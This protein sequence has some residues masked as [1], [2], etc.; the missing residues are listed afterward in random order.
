MADRGVFGGGGVNTCSQVMVNIGKIVDVTYI[1][2]KMVTEEQ[3]ILPFYFKDA[4]GLR[5]C[6]LNV[7]FLL[8]GWKVG[9]VG[10]TPWKK[11][12]F[13]IP[14]IVFWSLV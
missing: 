8:S 12:K 5:A 2:F 10:L 7:S 9:L 14:L 6:V 4:A 13:K 3:S 1:S 11:S